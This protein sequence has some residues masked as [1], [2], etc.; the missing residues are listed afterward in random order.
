MILT[1][2]EELQLK[3]GLDKFISWYETNI[4]E[5]DFPIKPDP[6]CLEC[7]HGVTPSVYNTGPCMYHLAKK[8]S[9]LLGG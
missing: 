9:K 4:D 7:T 6:F 8:Y 3:S 2:A 1:L 5:D